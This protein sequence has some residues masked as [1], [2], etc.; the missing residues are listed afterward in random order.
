[1]TMAHNDQ[2]VERCKEC[3]T[4]ESLWETVWLFPKQTVYLPYDP[5][6]ALLDTWEKWKKWKSMSTKNMYKI[7]HSTFIDKSKV[8]ET[9]YP[10]VSTFIAR[11]NLS[12]KKK[13]NIKMYN[14]L[15]GSCWVKKDNIKQ[16]HMLWLY[17]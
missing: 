16:S 2:D 12:N 14:N 4:V 15:E 6:M 1:M 5:V 17:F 7:A 3:E 8:L 10:P 13:Q 9:K 11:I